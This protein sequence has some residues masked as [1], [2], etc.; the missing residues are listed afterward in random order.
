MERK[1]NRIKMRRYLTVWF[2]AWML[3][4]T[5]VA[6]VGAER[7]AAYF[8]S[9][10]YTS[11]AEGG[12]EATIPA[13]NEPTYDCRFYQAYIG[14]D[15]GPWPGWIEELEQK[16]RRRENPRVLY[17]VLIA[18]YGYVA[19]LIGQERHDKAKDFLGQ[20][21]EHLDELDDFSAYRSYAESLRGAF[22]AYE[23]GMNRSKAV[24]LGPR[25]MKHINRAVE[26]DPGNP[27]AWME[28][29]NAEYHM[30]RIFGGSYHKAAEYFGKAIR[31]FESGGYDLQCNWRY[32]NALAW[33]AQSYDKAGK[34]GQASH[35]Y[36]KILDREPRFEW[37]RDELYPAFAEDHPGMAD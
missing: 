30:P 8:L 36:R 37:V 22:M 25:S 34:P 32:L 26:L 14:G 15:M 5:G 17:D 7:P 12:E 1:N 24:W 10:F 35:T 2:S 33:L 19:Y 20:A 11:P 29:G 23:I 27:I 9:P 3:F 16:Y 6:N 18:Y 4:F 28:K 31:L 21:E 13:D